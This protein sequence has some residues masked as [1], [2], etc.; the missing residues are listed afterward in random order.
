[1]CECLK[2]ADG[3]W[4]VDEC[5]ADVMD[6]WHAG[7]TVRHDSCTWTE[8]EDGNWGTSCGNLFVLTEGGPLRNGMC[9]CCY[10]GGELVERPMPEEEESTDA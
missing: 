6:K 4:H 8:D 1:M 10:C 5:C 9:W 3:T 2:R 7:G